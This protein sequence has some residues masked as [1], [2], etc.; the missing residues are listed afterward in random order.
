MSISRIS[1]CSLSEAD[2]IA[3]FKAYQGAEIPVADMGFQTN[4][5]WTEY[6]RLSEADLADIFA[7]LMAQPPVSNQVTPRP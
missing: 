4:H 1:S 2:F 3:R 6:A 5:A 7:Y